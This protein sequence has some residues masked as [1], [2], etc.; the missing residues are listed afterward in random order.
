MT[1]QLLTRLRAAPAIEGSYHICAVLGRGYL[2]KTP[3]GKGALLVPCQ[4][5]TA[6]LGRTFGAMLLKFKSEVAFDVD[7]TR[8]DGSAALVE[9]LEDELLPT[10]LALARDVMTSIGDAGELT[11]DAIVRALGHWEL[12]LRSRALLSEEAQL[13]LWGELL[14][15]TQKGVN[16]GAFR[17][18]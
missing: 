11:A 6:T 8:W 13:G 1:Q 16:P 9:C 12:L 7:G 14:P 3:S 5:G 18:A 10:F 17:W 4:R 2:A 15:V